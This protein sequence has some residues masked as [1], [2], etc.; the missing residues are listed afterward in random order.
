MKIDGHVKFQK[1]IIYN[2]TNSKFLRVYGQQG[3]SQVEDS[4]IVDLYWERSEQAISETQNKYGHY[5]LSIA[6]NILPTREDAQE[7]VNDTYLAAWNAMPPNRPSIL[8]TFLGKLTRRISI[9]KWRI[10]SADKRGGGNTALALEELAECIPGGSDPEAEVEAKELASTI[11][12]FLDTLSSTE[13]QIFLMRYFDLTNIQNISSKFN[14]SPSK[15]KSMLFRIRNK[16]RE[17]LEK[18]GY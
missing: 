16:L 12:S 5:C 1:I 6:R 13:R 10:L 8:S 17:H 4:K 3:V 11:G 14:M 9:D 2:A 18:E 7:S 15:V